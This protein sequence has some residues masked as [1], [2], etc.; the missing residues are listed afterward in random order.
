MSFGELVHQPVGPTGSI[1]VI[2]FSMRTQR[3]WCSRL[4]YSCLYQVSDI[5]HPQLR[6]RRNDWEVVY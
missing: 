2:Q 5:I 1:F 3:T 6:S 4:R